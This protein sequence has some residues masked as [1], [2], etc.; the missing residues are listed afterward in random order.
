MTETLTA[1]QW[2][3]RLAR[4]EAAWQQSEASTGSIYADPPDGDYQFT[5]YSFDFIDTTSHGAFL[6]TELQVA[7]GPHQGKVTSTMH[8]LEDPDRFG[9]LKAHLALLSADVDN[10]ALSDIHPGSSVLEA[11]LDTPVEGTV[12]R[13]KKL[14]EDGT[15]YVNVYVN[16]RLGEPLRKDMPPMPNGAQEQLPPSDRQDVP[17]DTSDFEAAAAAGPLKTK[18]EDHDDDVPWTDEDLADGPGDHDTA[19]AAPAAPAA[20]C[21][22]PG[23]PTHVDSNCPVPGHQIGF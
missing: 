18:A 13:S 8:S 4:Q 14:R 19:A 12:K 5:V 15:P 2:Q 16:K 6:K 10:L 11:L 3:E 21:I 9:Y 23:F 22:C 20:G 7:S 17:G 1:A